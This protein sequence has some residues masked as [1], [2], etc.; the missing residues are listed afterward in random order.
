MTAE[1]VTM[2]FKGLCTVSVEGK[3]ISLQSDAGK[4]E[5]VFLLGTTEDLFKVSI[6][7]LVLPCHRVFHVVFVALQGIIMIGS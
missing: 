1:A 5:I 7:M 3:C 6:K 2:S 4:D